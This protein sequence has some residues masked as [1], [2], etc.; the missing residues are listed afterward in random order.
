MAARAEPVHDHA[1]DAE[2]HLQA[3]QEVPGPGARGQ[4]G[5][6]G[7]IGALRRD[8]AHAGSLPQRRDLQHPLVEMQ[9]GAKAAGGREHSPHGT[10][11]VQYPGL[12][13]IEANE[14]VRWA[15]G[16]E[17]GVDLGGPEHLVSQPVGDR[18]RMAAAEHL[19]FWRAEEQTA[20]DREQVLPRIMLQ[21]IPQ[22]IGSQEQRDVCLALEIGLT[23]DA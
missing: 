12:C 17:A 8:D 23:D 19:A 2:G 13:L 10:L 15:K 4:D 21:L 18:A 20:C 9:A 7:H 22:L 1:P 3:L 11:R 16:W 6:P 14:V 5:P